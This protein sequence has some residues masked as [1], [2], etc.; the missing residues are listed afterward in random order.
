MSKQTIPQPGIL[1]KKPTLSVCMIVRDEEKMLPRCLKSVQSIADELIVVDTG[2]KDNT[3][4]IAKDFGAKVF[5]FKWR[6][7]FA[8][9][10]N[11]SLKYATGDWI[12]QIDA[13]EELLSNSIAHLK[14]RM[15]RSAVLYYV[16]RCDNGPRCRGPRFS[17]LGR[18][19]RRHP[20]LRYHRPYHE[21]IDCSVQNLIIAEP[22]W[23]MQYEPSII[24][25]HYGYEQSKVPKKRE[26][27]LLIMKSYLKENPNDAY[28]LSR[29]GGVC[30]GLG[31]DVMMK[32]GHI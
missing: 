12:L 10:R 8:A 15:S 11:E 26:R 3:I 7:D 32:Q 25:R 18:L 27:G 14:D 5:H 6:D 22:R 19:F 28:I 16:I 2:S 31:Q 1:P 29:L 17:R 9:A 21:G 30:C 20:K 24:I 23:K 13:D 4:S